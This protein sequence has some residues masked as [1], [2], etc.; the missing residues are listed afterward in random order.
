MQHTQHACHHTCVLAPTR[1]VRQ[2]ARTRTPGV[3]ATRP[4][5]TNKTRVPCLLACWRRKRRVAFTQQQSK[6]QLQ[7]SPCDAANSRR[8]PCGCIWGHAYVHVS[9][10]H[11]TVSVEQAIGKKTEA[12]VAGIVLRC[13]ALHRAHSTHHHHH[14]HH[15]TAVAAAAC[16]SRARRPTRRQHCCFRPSDV[17]VGGV[18]VVE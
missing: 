4:P 18:V 8:R 16:V 2:H 10:V 13:A 9:H 17:F 5:T 7:G 14:H 1:V 12:A 6:Q 11:Q 3:Q 15:Q